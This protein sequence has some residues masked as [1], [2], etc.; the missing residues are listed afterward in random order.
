MH[1]IATQEIKPSRP[2]EVMGTS[3]S[4]MD[5]VHALGD[6]SVRQVVAIQT[7]VTVF[8]LLTAIVQQKSIW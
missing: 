1:L 5:L 7:P 2:G 6:L 3:P 8:P 4:S